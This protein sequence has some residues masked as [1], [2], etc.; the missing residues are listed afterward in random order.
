[1]ALTPEEAAV[2]LQHLALD[3]HDEVDV[4]SRRLPRLIDT[5]TPDVVAEARHDMQENAQDALACEMGSGALM[6]ALDY[7][8]KIRFL[9]DTYTLWGEDGHF[10]F[11]DGDTWERSPPKTS[12]V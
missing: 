10:T 6:A 4:V 1:M 3:H 5:E 8:A 7:A 9:L 12:S 11:A 2:Q